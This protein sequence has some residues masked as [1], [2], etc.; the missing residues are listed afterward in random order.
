MVVEHLSRKR[1]SQIIEDKLPIIEIEHRHILGCAECREQLAGLVHEYE[2]QL[3]Q[4]K[5][6]QNLAPVAMLLAILI[7]SLIFVAVIIETW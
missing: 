4:H 2:K 5:K 6:R 3:L 7:V 1:L